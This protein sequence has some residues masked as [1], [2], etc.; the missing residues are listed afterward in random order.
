[1]PS[2][3]PQPAGGPF[4]WTA[5]DAELPAFTGDVEVPAFAGGAE[6]TSPAESAPEAASPETAGGE[7]ADDAPSGIPEPPEP[8]WRAAAVNEAV[9]DTSVV[10]PVIDSAPSV[11]ATSNDETPAFAVPT[12]P[13]GG[14][15][16]DVEDDFFGRDERSESSVRRFLFGKKGDDTTAVDEESDDREFKW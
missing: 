1:L 9:V 13:D 4:P 11:A 14:A 7:H 2:D 5:G 6:S 8:A 3:V 15:S 16:S 12:S 10:P